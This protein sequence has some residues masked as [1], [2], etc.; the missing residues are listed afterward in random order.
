ME[1]ETKDKISDGR[2][3]DFPVTLL[4]FIGFCGIIGLLTTVIIGI[5]LPFAFIFIAFAGVGLPWGLSRL[6]K[7][8][9]KNKPIVISLIASILLSPVYVPIGV[10]MGFSMPLFPSYVK[11][12]FTGPNVIQ[13]VMSPDG[14]FEAYVVETPSIDPPNQS[15]YIQRSDNI[16]F[17][18]IA[19]LAGDIDSIKKI[20][21][22]PQSDIV[23]FH[24]RCHL[25]AVR[26]PGYQTVKI[27]LGGEWIRTK[28]SKRSTFS[29][30]GPR[31]AVADIQFPQP[32]SFSYRLEGA[33]TFKIIPMSSF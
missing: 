31:V 12:F 10:G 15:L 17:L 18:F 19:K 25:I 21:W 32:C 27:P 7:K 13:S 22:S 8:E 5:P 2:S 11:I 9:R 30:A 26:V 33:D 28:A 23:V 6:A 4:L 14:D 1:E 29:G 3:R 24:T 20:H 16:H